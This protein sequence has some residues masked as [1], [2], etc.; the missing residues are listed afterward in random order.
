MIVLIR[1]FY[2][3]FF[4]GADLLLYSLLH[5]KNPVGKHIIFYYLF[6]VVVVSIL[7]AGLFNISFLMP[8]KDFFTCL[9]CLLIILI[10]HFFGILGTRRIYNPANRVNVKIKKI[11]AGFWQFMTMT[12]PYFLLFLVQCLAALFFPQQ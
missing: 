5:Q 9:G 6:L 4:G 7:H 11:I 12:M 1:L 3:L 2:I 8:V 10:T